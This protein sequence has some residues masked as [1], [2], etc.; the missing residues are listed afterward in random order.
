MTKSELL[1]EIG[2]AL[3]ELQVNFNDFE[4]NKERAG[5]VLEVLLNTIQKVMEKGD[6][7]YMRGFGSFIN[8]KRAKKMGRNVKAKTS[9]VIDAH[10]VPA[11]K[12]AKIFTDKIKSSANLKEK[13]NNEEK[14]T[15]K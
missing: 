3:E 10:F 7:I 12:P 14:D 1:T 9:V 8:K 15:K 13:L 4:T 6:N 5:V 11:F 2:N